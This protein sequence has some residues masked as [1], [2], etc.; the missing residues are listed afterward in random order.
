[1]KKTTE[2][3]ILKAALMVSSMSPLRVLRMQVGAFSAEYNN[4]KRFIRMGVPGMADL[5]VANG[6]RFAWVEVK[7][8]SGRQNPH[9]KNFQRI[10]EANNTR[11]F[12]VRSA[13]DI[14]KVRRVM[15]GSAAA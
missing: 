13:E 14:E 8:P 12:I 9:Q 4:K 3:D 7:S 1:M 11:Y 2:S 10:E 5:M 6:D 15:I